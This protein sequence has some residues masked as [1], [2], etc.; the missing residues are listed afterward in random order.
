MLSNIWS[1]KEIRI[2]LKN[3]SVKRGIILAKMNFKISPLFV[4]IPLFT[5]NIYFEFQVYMFSNGRD[6]DKMSQFLHDDDAKA[7]AIPR[8]FTGNSRAK[9]HNNINNNKDFFNSN[10]TTLTT[11]LT[12]TKLTTTKATTTMITLIYASRIWS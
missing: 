4:H 12:T 3:L 10:K 7:T 9:K 1:I 6:N 8:A 5:V 11:I 2:S